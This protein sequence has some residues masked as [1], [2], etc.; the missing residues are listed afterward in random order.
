MASAR[1]VCCIALTSRLAVLVLQVSPSMDLHIRACAAFCMAK[2][3]MPFN[4]H[5]NVN[6]T[7]TVAQT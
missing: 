2:S 6:Y 5:R 4:V 3:S 7:L 1:S